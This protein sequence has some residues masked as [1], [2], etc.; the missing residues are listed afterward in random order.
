GAALMPLSQA[1]LL[2]INP[3]ERHGQA[4]A[5]W[6]TGA[7]I[8]PIAGPA[9]G[10]WLT[11]NYNWRWVFYINLPIGIIAFLGILFF[12][13]ESRHAHRERFDFFGFAALGVAIGALQMLLDRGELKDWFHSTEIWLEATIAGLALYLFVVHTVTTREPPFLNRDLLRDRNFVVGLVLMFFVGVIMFATLALL[14]TM[15]QQSMNYPVATAGLVI[16]PRGI[17][18]MVAM[19]LVGRVIGLVDIR[20]LILS[21]LA[22]TTVSLYQMSGFSLA[23]D[24]QPIVVSGLVQGFGLGFVFVP[25]S[26]ISFSTLPRSVLTQGTAIFSLMRNIGSSIGIA[27][28]EA[29]FVEN[30][31]IVHSRLVEQLR[32]DNPL[33]QAPYLLSPY[34]LSTTTGIAAL[35]AEV[36]RQA[37]MI[38]Y[39]DDFKLMMV[40]AV[41]VA[42]LLLLLHKPRA[43]RA[44]SSAAAE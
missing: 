11:D 9:L 23:M 32:P 2:R 15:L 38:A 33:A 3:P 7:M 5:I 44:P 37:Q 20:L 26:T 40:I 13:Q 28:L 30:T 1:V 36:T 8:G 22:L 19:F 4:M 31:Q 27:I 21:G 34:S 17:G 25:L 18:T 41:L 10:G 12:I 6:G 29:L 39:I 14:P 16:A 35:N 24:T 43:E 42:P